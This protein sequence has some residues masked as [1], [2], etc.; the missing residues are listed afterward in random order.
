YRLNDHFSFVHTLH[1]N[2]NTNDIGYAAKAADQAIVFGN[3]D[4]TTVE[5]VFSSDYILTN[6]MYFS[7]RMRQYW[8]KGE[9]NEFYRLKEDGR[10]E[11]GYSYDGNKDF[12]FNSFNIDFV[13]T[14]LFAP[15]SS[16]NVVWKNA[17]LHEQSGLVANYFDN[18][19][20][21]RQAPQY[22]SLSLKILYYLDYQQIRGA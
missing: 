17:V 11:E 14:W 16:L 2:Y 6:E 9:Y 13:F 8:S 1:M 22:N 20:L 10:L 19:D 12:N 7:F 5:N 18:F 3:R 15:G 21:I 4:V